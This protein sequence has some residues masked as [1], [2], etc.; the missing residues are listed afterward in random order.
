MNGFKD[1]NFE[2]IGKGK[3]KWQVQYGNISEKVKYT[4]EY[5]INEKETIGYTKVE[6]KDG[7]VV[8][9]FI[10]RMPDGK[11]IITTT[12]IQAGQ[13]KIGSVLL[14]SI[15][16]QGTLEEHYHS[17]IEHFGGKFPLADRKYLERQVKDLPDRV[18]E[19]AKTAILQKMGL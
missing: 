8:H 11:E 15:S 1:E 16:P 3:G 10:S 5:F 14:N 19:L 17:H 6:R 7:Q 13:L 9:I 18:Y 12:G 4:A 2:S